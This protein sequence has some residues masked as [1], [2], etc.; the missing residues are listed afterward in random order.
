MRLH[1]TCVVLEYLFVARVGELAG[2]PPS[3]VYCSAVD[4]AIFLRVIS[5]CFV[6][7]KAFLTTPLLIGT[8]FHCAGPP[9]GE[10]CAAAAFYRGRTLLRRH[11]RGTA[12]RVEVCSRASKGHQITSRGGRE[13]CSLR[14]HVDISRRGWGDCVNAR[15]HAS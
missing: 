2:G 9:Y 14:I 15:A 12:V 1:S 8:L 11:D 7:R 6:C 3:S 13:V 4:P 5:I 10:S